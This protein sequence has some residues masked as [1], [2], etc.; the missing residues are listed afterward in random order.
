MFIFTI[1]MIFSANGNVSFDAIFNMRNALVRDTANT[2]DYY[3]YQEGVGQNR[4]SFAAAVGM[5]QS[6]VSFAIVMGANALSR[7]IRG[8]GAF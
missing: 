5:A 1:G 2:I 8:Y 3:I 7:R 4:M 6:V